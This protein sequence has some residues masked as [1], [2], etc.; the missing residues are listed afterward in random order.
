MFEWENYLRRQTDLPQ[1]IPSPTIRILGDNRGESLGV[2]AMCWA[3]CSIFC[4]DDSVLPSLVDFAKSSA[5]HRESA[6]Q[7][8]VTS[9]NPVLF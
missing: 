4:F 6:A 2:L 3:R 7:S 5:L 9:V 8:R 1:T